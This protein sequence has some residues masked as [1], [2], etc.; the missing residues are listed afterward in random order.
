[1]QFNKVYV[2][3]ISLISILMV[4]SYL[5]PV[6]PNGVLLSDFQAA[7]S[8]VTSYSS[9]NLSRT[10]SSAHF[11]WKPVCISNRIAGELAEGRVCKSEKCFEGNV[12]F[13]EE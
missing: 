13:R 7:A 8:S 12:T 9:F 3:A 1:M 5:A 11:A 6:C 2:L 10:K 4:S